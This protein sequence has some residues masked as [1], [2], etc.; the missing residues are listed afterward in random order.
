M[1]RSATY[2]RAVAC[3]AIPAV[4]LAALLLAG[5]AQAFTPAAK[6]GSEDAPLRLSSPAVGGH[7]STSGPSIVR[8][9]VGLLIVIALIWGLAWILRQVKSARDTRVVG[10][11][12]ASM[13]TLPLGSGRTLHLVR[14]GR[15]YLVVGSA[16]HGVV[17]IYRYTEEQARDAGLLERVEEAAAGGAAT[18]VASAG[19]AAAAGGDSNLIGRLR[20]WTVRR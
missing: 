6:G 14:T 17:P 1:T 4:G 13:A 11:A 18:S 16:E 3:T 12:L 8:T 5:P 19:M 15:D 20:E 7:T 9:I 10:S 2:S